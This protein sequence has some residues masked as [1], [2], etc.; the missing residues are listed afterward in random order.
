ML[1]NKTEENNLKVGLLW[2]V[3]F[4]TGY[5]EV[6]NFK[7]VCKILLININFEINF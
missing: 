3:F 6:A 2:L 4:K 1:E 5:L 7:I